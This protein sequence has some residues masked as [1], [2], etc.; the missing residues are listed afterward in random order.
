MKLDYRSHSFLIQDFDGHTF[1]EFMQEITGIFEQNIADIQSLSVFTGFES[2]K[3]KSI[4]KALTRL[5]WPCSKL[6]GVNSQTFYYYHEEITIWI[7]YWWQEGSNHSDGKGIFIIYWILEYF[8]CTYKLEIY[9][10]L[11]F[12]NDYQ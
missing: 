6:F 4:K 2:T 1:S 8:D 9:G 11:L 3:V 5:E 12:P 10:G 7:S